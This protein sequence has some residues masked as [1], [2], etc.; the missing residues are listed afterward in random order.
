MR[1]ITTLQEGDGKILARYLQAQGIEVVLRADVHGSDFELWVVDEED[2]ERVREITAAFRKDPFDARYRNVTPLPKP[3]REQRN[4][5]VDV[6]T[7]VFH[8]H[9]QVRGKL[10][11]ALIAVSVLVFLLQKSGL[12]PRFIALLLISEFV[13]PAFLE[14][15]RGQL[16]RLLTPIFLHFGILHIIFNMLWLYQLGNQVERCASPRLL[17]LLVVV[18]GVVSNVSQY[19]ITGP[20]FGGFSGVVYGLLGYVWI[21]AQFKPASGYVMDR[22]TVGFML[23]WL[24][25]G[26][27]G[28][29][30]GIANAAH[31]FGLLAGVLWGLYTVR[32]RRKV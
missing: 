14:V 4:R 17:A 10:T 30:G 18:I 9:A 15:Q 5:Y 8:R 6:R 21:M 7:Q 20:L 24:L 3:Q 25:L 19:L 27:S 13:Q 2:C 28:L 32:G 12:A 16:W 23:A 29:M 1:K 11:V 26:L 22:F 31:L